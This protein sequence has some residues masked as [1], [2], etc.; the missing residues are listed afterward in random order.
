MFKIDKTEN[1][2]KKGVVAYTSNPFLENLTIPIGKKYRRREGGTFTTTG[3]NGDQ[4]EHQ[5]AEITQ[6]EKVD[7]DQFV[8]LYTSEIRHFFNLK[9]STQK[10]LMV[11]LTALQE[12]PN[13]DQVYLDIKHVQRFFSDEKIM[14]RATFSAAV[15][16]L[17]E[18]EFI[19]ECALQTNQYY[20]NPALFF[21]GDRLRIVKEYVVDHN[22]RIK[23]AAKD[24][25]ENAKREEQQEE[26]DI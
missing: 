25:T 14:T 7:K 21:N 17:I 5:I 22:K 23:N 9:P 15:K 24:L 6:I 18:K 8:K 10:I 12:L 11:V 2:R 3:V 1:S 26:M 20:I 4:Q 19:A 13:K 16:E